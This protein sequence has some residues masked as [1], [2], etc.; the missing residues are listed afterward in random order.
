M[1]PIECGIVSCV[2]CEPF[3]GQ[4]GYCRYQEK[5]SK[6][7]ILKFRAA[8]NLEKGTIIMLECL[9]MALPEGEAA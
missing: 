6:G 3:N 5:E 9:N 2:Y 4:Y 8:F 1:N 7:V